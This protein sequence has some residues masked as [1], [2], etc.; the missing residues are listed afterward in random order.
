M[1]SKAFQ[2]FTTFT[3]S[4]TSRY[5]LPAAGCGDGRPAQGP[6][7]GQT[8]P[9]HVWVRGLPVRRGPLPLPDGGRPPGHGHQAG[10]QLRLEDPAHPD[11]GQ[12]GGRGWGPPEERL[13]WAAGDGARLLRGEHLWHSSNSAGIR[14]WLEAR[15]TRWPFIV[16]LVWHCHI[17]RLGDN[18]SIFFSPHRLYNDINPLQCQVTIM[19]G[20][21]FLNAL[22]KLVATLFHC[23]MLEQVFT[24][25]SCLSLSLSRVVKCT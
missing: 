4:T 6:D 20:F 1:F 2:S 25:K 22:T 9:V 17:E 8:Q 19:S 16:W 24:C 10:L 12:H 18:W 23:S 7:G 5:R 21:I 3:S 15:R 14:T 11:R 13:H